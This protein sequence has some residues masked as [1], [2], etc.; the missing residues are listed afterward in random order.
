[1][2]KAIFIF[3]VILVTGSSYIEAQNATYRKITPATANRMMLEE[4]D[5]VLLDVRTTGEFNTRRI[6]GAILIPDNEIRRRAGNELPD[7]NILI[8]VYC[9]GGV[10]SERAARELVRMGYTNVYDFG[11]INSWVYG[12]ISG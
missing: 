3:C 12:T 8:F 6:E 11:G 1:M 5:F 4:N 7:K 2:K 10:R 9:Q